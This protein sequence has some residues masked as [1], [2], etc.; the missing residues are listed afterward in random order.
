[1]TIKLWP[2]IVAACVASACSSKPMG[3]EVMNVSGEELQVD[4]ISAPEL[5]YNPPVGVLGRYSKSSIDALNKPP[6]TVTIDVQGRP[7]VIVDVPPLPSDAKGDITLMLVYTRARRWSGAWEII[8]AHDEYG[9]PLGT[10][11]V[12]D[13]SNGDYRTHVALIAAAKAGNVAEVDRLIAQ[14]APIYWRS[15]DDSPLT[16]ATLWNRNAVIERLLQPDLM[17]ETRDIEE[18][19]VLA[20]DPYDSDISTLRLLVGRFGPTLS[21]EVRARAL[22]RAAEANRSDD[23]NQIIPAGP[24]VRYLVDEA[25][26][27][28]NMPVFDDGRTI[29]DFADQKVG[30]FR[31]EP[32]MEFLTS[33]GARSGLRPAR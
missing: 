16:I 22:R 27:D 5:R 15:T 3:I 12:P 33:H 4:R 23:A 17:I 6:V 31:D 13:D 21:Q 7:P 29:F 24:A 32:L 28:V 11:L 14:G 10:R 18:A 25:G 2:T 19:I 9:F 26:F 8:P 20:S 30:R 1:M